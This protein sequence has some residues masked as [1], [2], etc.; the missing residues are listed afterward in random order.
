VKTQTKIRIA[1]GL[2]TV[3][4]GARSL[5]GRGPLLRA[6]RGG[7]AWDL[8]LNEGIEFAIYLGVY[9][10]LPERVR[11]LWVRPG[12]CV[13]DIGANIGA[14]SL[15]LLRQVGPAG[16][17]ISVEPTDY[18]FRR[19]IANADLNPELAPR[20]VAIQAGLDDGT[21]PGAAKEYFSR[22]PLDGKMDGR[23]ERHLG[24]PEGAEAARS[25]TLD[26]LVQELRDAG[27]VAAMP[28]FIKLDVDGHE[29]AVLKGGRTVL[30][31]A[32]P[33]LLIEFAPH[34]QD[35]VVGR[36]E[37]LIA[38]IADYGYALERPSSGA[39]L[40]LDAGKL[41]SL[42]GD[43]ASLDVLAVPR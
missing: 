3:V 24:Q 2:K 37:Q 14:F 40:P 38:T 43:S 42:I 30:S 10:R 41:R 9:Q 35:E 7:V 18:A 8:D 17:V 4:V 36:F 33:A 39:A 16:T 13:M 32:R 11:Q 20:L 1:R 25:L 23:H 12:A 22:W 26:A 21:Q 5:A 27:R 6:H 15:P 31:E 28:T 34:V 29:L 19:L